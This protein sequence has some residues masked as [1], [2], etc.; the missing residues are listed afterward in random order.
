ME[1]R[2]GDGP[3]WTREEEQRYWLLLEQ[4]EKTRSRH[5]WML[6]LLAVVMAFLVVIAGVVIMCSQ[7]R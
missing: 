5:I 6:T 1:A 3:G 7:P 2:M 4:Q